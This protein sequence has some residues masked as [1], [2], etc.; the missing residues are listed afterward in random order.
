MSVTRELVDRVQPDYWQ[1]WELGYEHVSQE[2]SG[3]AR[4]RRF[5]GLTR[6]DVAEL[7]DGML[8]EPQQELY[9]DYGG[10]IPELDD[11]ILYARIFTAAPLGNGE[12]WA[13]GLQDRGG[14]PPLKTERKPEP[15]AGW[16]P[17]GLLNYLLDLAGEPILRERLA[18]RD[19][20][21]ARGEPSRGG[22]LP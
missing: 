13:Y 2:G 9:E 22:N 11:L 14:D 20:A 4:L 1:A 8:P 12:D 17:G 19:A 15:P 7:A 10:G 3:L 18:E 21:E 6:A 16:S 5:Y